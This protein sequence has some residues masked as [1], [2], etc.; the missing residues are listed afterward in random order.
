MVYSTYDGTASGLNEVVWAPH[1]SLP[2]AETTLRGLVK[3]DYQSD[4]D[5]GENFLNFMLHPDLRP[6]C[7]VDVTLTQS[8]KP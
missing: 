7:G 6:F 3:G 5:I 1:F 8:T 4:L 2:I